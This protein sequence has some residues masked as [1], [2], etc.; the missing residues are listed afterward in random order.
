MPPV[1]PNAPTRR[2]EYPDKAAAFGFCGVCFE[3]STDVLLAHFF[4]RA[5]ACLLICA[6]VQ[7]AIAF[8][9]VLRECIRRME[10]VNETLAHGSSAIGVD[11]VLNSISG[12][13]HCRSRFYL[14]YL[15]DLFADTILQ[16]VLFQVSASPRC[17]CCSLPLML[18][19]LVL[20]LSHRTG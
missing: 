12:A 11:A 18:L 19:L 7:W 2:L 3:G 5:Q 16:L 6:R 8:L 10:P 14:L 17:C 4:R 9:S 15:T 13:M 20:T 1:H